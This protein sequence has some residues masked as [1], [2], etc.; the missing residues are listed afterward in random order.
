MRVSRNFNVSLRCTRCSASTRGHDA[1]LRAKSRSK[2]ICSFETAPRLGTM[3]GREVEPEFRKDHGL[4]VLTKMVLEYRETVEDASNTQGKSVILNPTHIAKALGFPKRRLYDVFNVCEG[5]GALKRHTYI[6]GGR[7][8]DFNI[9]HGSVETLS[10]DSLWAQYKGRAMISATTK[11]KDRKSGI[12]FYPSSGDTP[13][14]KGQHEDTVIKSAQFMDPTTFKTGTIRKAR[15]ISIRFLTYVFI[16]HL[17]KAGERGSTIRD[18]SKALSKSYPGGSARLLYDIINV[19]LPL[20]VIGKVGKKAFRWMGEGGTDRYGTPIPTRQQDEEDE[21]STSSSWAPSEEEEGRATPDPE[22]ESSGNELCEDHAMMMIFSEDQIIR[23]RPA[24]VENVT[25][26]TTVKQLVDPGSFRDVFDF[27][28]LLLQ[29]PDVT[30][31]VPFIGFQPMLMPPQTPLLFNPA[32]TMG[33]GHRVKRITK[34]L[35]EALG[36]PSPK[37]DRIQ[38]Y[39]FVMLDEPEASSDKDDEEE[40]DDSRL[41]KRC[42]CELD[43]C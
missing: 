20:G 25:T 29:E 13:S 15:S 35:A 42:R 24:I 14:G 31:F 21:N 40:E 6:V 34:K 27:S 17:I 7:P 5:A 10:D 43:R 22:Q 23:P 41:C 9:W 37:R 1:N 16:A 32:L 33:R 38:S 30:G 26:T 8:R 36:D 2:Y 12:M 28:D 4:Q 18:A 19:L 3:W 39:R 11:N